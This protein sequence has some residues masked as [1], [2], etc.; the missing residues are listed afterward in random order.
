MPLCYTRRMSATG[1]VLQFAYRLQRHTRF[2]WPLARWLGLLLLGMAGWAL[3]R[4]WPFAWQSSLLV[5][6]FVAYL[7]ML[8]W[9]G[10]SGYV[11]FAEHSVLE[12]TPGDLPP[13]RT[14]ELVPV[15]ASGWFTV[16]DEERYFVDV[17]AG[18]ETVATRE[19][20]VMGQ[21]A[22][23]RFLL[24]GRWPGRDT[25]WWYIFF[26][27]ATIRGVQVGHLTTGLRSRPALRIETA[28]DADTRRAI[29]LAFEDRESLRRVW[30]D[31][32]VDGEGVS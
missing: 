14:E 21:I 29:Y 5:G 9:A 18:F 28:P 25:G 27:P 3:F 26:Q 7:L 13:L 2:G 11:R 6:L 23:S 12:G 32:V 31:L 4:W 8:V 17:E 1:L 10:R 20:I 16:M 15:R 19:H 24:V 22:P 30:D